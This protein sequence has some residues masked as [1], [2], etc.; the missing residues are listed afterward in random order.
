MR[1]L[2]ILAFAVIVTACSISGATSP[3]TPAG[4]FDLTD[5]DLL[6]RLGSPPFT[7]IAWQRTVH[8]ITVVG[9]RPHPDPVEL[10]LIGAALDELPRVLFDV[11][12]PRSIIR[13]PSAPDEEHVGAAVAFT[14]GPD[15]YLVDRTFILDGVRTTRLD[16]ARAL[17]HEFSHVAQFYALNPTYIQAALDG[18]VARVDPA[19]GSDLVTSFA[20]ATGWSNRSRDPVHADWQLSDEASTEYGRTG[21][22]EDMAESV[23]MLVL[24]RAEWIPSDRTKWVTR[25]LDTSADRLATGKPWIPAGA[26]EVVANQDVYDEEAAGRAAPGADHLEAHYFELPADLPDYLSLGPKIERELLGRGFGGIF[27]RIQD[28]Q[29]PHYQGSFSRT[30]GVRFW[31]EFWDFRDATGFVSAPDVPVLVYVE[32]W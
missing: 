14:R 31:V 15:V 7:D 17:A 28:A 21:P 9:S 16:L 29:V 2:L 25:W 24:G 6:T 19:D 13:I 20:D 26:I 27:T 11:G 3:T 30:D 10:E 1:R 8:D 22:A 4:S 5:T 32:L 18:E 23:A 12:T